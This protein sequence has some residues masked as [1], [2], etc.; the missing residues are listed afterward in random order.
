MN[1]VSKMTLLLSDRERMHL[2]RL[3]LS[4]ASAAVMTIQEACTVIG[5]EC[6]NEIRCKSVVD[7]TECLRELG[8]KNAA[9]ILAFC[10]MAQISEDLIVYDLGPTTKSLQMAALLRRFLTHEIN[11]APAHEQ[12]LLV[13]E[14]AHTLFACTVCKK[15]MTAHVKDVFKRHRRPFNE[16]GVSSSMLC[17]DSDTREHCIL[18]ARRTTAAVRSAIAF[19]DDMFTHGIES[20]CVERK[21]LDSILGNSDCDKRRTMFSSLARDSKSTLEQRICSVQCGEEPMLKVPILGKAVRLWNEWYALCAFCGCV[22][23]FDNASRASNEICCMRCDSDLILADTSTISKKDNTKESPA[24]C[25]YCNKEDPFKT[26]TRW[27]KVRAPL[28]TS[29]ENMRLPPPLRTVYFC[30]QH[31]KPWIPACLKVMQTRVVLS[32]IVYGAKPYYVE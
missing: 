6:H 11:H 17:I 16:V 13:P 3:A 4:T 30:P 23:C 7:S 2:N 29:G 15:G 27:K 8:G 10:R 1:S 20:A 9:K 32:H 24:I 14:H 28:D 19:E 18:C 26:G 22:V 12:M 25:R 21:R 5:I 31:Y